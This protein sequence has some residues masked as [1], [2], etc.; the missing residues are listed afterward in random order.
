MSIAVLDAQ[1]TFAV[2][3]DLCLALSIEE[4]ILVS[5]TVIR[6]MKEVNVGAY[7]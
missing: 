6:D 5:Y 1:R 3:V 7:K 2:G 4:N